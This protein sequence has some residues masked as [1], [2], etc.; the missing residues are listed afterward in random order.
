[1]KTIQS[2]L[3]TIQATLKNDEYTAF[4]IGDYLNLIRH[5]EQDGEA[6]ISI[7]R[8]YKDARLVKRY[9]QINNL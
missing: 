7:V 3:N 1:M 5:W 8:Q 2:K 4:I 6:Q 9:K